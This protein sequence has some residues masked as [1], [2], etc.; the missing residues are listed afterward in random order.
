MPN[1]SIKAIIF[2]MGGVFVQTMDR[3]PRTYLAERLNLS[4][5]E[6]SQIVFGSETARKATVGELD[7]KDHWVFLADHFRLSMEEMDEFWNEF[8]GGDNLD[9]QLVDFAKTLKPDYKVALLSNAWS[10]ARDL[11]S[12]KFGFLDIFDVSV[13]SAE[14]KMAKPDEKFYNWML[15]QLDIRPREAIFVDD[16]IE[17]IKAAQ[18]MGINTVQFLDTKQTIKDIKQILGS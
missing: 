3:E 1:N 4:Y 10:G 18:A 7:E 17:N 9:K 16:F 5:D 11:L 6:L 8:W 15:K 2:D 13:F 12:R 14:V